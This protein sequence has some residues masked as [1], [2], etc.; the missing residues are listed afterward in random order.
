MRRAGR[1]CQ[2]TDEPALFPH[3]FEIGGLS[4]KYD[5]S[6]NQIAVFFDII[7]T[8]CVSEADD[9]TGC[10]RQGHLLLSGELVK[11][12]QYLAHGYTSSIAILSVKTALSVSNI[13]PQ[14]KYVTE[15]IHESFCFI[16]TDRSTPIKPSQ[17]SLRCG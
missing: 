3:G 11:A 4:P 15:L 1:G 8:S 9:D 16:D 7:Q 14:N 6:Y 17:A 2:L 10:I 5:G 12:H 13:R